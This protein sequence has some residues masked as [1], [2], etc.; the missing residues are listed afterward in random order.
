[1]AES[2]L[3]LHSTA[4][5]DVGYV[6]A[7]NQDSAFA[8]SRLIAIADGMGGHAGGD[9]AS[10]IAIRTL[11]HLECAEHR[12]NIAGTTAALEKSILAAHDAIV[13]KAKK[14]HELAGMGTTVDA[15]AL[16]RGYWILAHIG[17]SRAYLLRGGRLIRVSKDH[18]YVQHLIDTR[19]I[20]PTEAKNHPQRNVVMRVLGDFDIDPHPDISVRAAAPGDRWLLCSDGLCGPLEDETI[21]EVLSSTIDREECA[22]QLV[23]MALKAGSTDNVSAV[24]GDAVTLDRAALRKGAGNPQVPLIAGAAAASLASIADVVHRA[25][26]TAPKLRGE[27]TPAQKAAEL[28]DHADAVD[29]PAVA[30]ALGI[31][32]LS[33]DQRI[34]TPSADQEEDSPLPDTGEIPIVTKSDGSVSTDPSDP[35]VVEAVKDQAEEEA[36][37]SHQHKIRRRI[38]K[39]VGSLIVLIVLVGGAYGAW[40]WS[41]SQYYLGASDGVVAIYQGVPTNVFGL[42]LSHKVKDTETKTTSLPKSWRDQLAAG[43]TADSYQE[44][45]DHATVIDKQA[46]A[47]AKKSGANGA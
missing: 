20:T 29:D 36:Q 44:A 8:G 1:M 43:I 9:T 19:R 23:N 2:E 41:Q 16:V 37:K 31:D 24:V 6:R 11:A 12:Q 13:G 10:T 38:A 22:Q 39:I 15:V 17:D 40:S 5:S 45:V 7:N 30:E 28:I 42:Q 35:E 21:A 33:A 3:F 14:E 46:Q 32:H 18:S 47:F 26:A 25:V 34:A 27:K 4:L